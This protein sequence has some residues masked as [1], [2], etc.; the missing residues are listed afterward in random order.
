MPDRPTSRTW[1][2]QPRPLRWLWL[3]VA[4]IQA[5]GIVFFLIVQ[6]WAWVAMAAVGL[7]VALGW[8]ALGRGG[9]TADQE[10]LRAMRPK[11][12][13]VPWNDVLGFRRSGRDLQDVAARLADGTERTLTVP[14]QRPNEL[15][16]L[17]PPRLQEAPVAQGSRLTHAVRMAPT[18]NGPLLNRVDNSSREQRPYSQRQI[19]SLPCRL[20]RGVILPDVD[21]VAPSE[22]GAHDTYY[23]S[24]VGQ[25]GSVDS[26]GAPS[27]KPFESSAYGST[28]T[29]RHCLSTQRLMIRRVRICG[30]SSGLWISWACRP[31]VLSRRCSRRHGR[32]VSSSARASAAR[33]PGWPRWTSPTHLTPSC[34]RVGRQ[35][36]PF[37][38]RRNR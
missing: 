35:P 7:A 38:L 16:E 2:R 37:T 32:M 3:A 8:Y 21:R 11:D 23:G 27:C 15:L 19:R 29:P 25:Y 13:L 26:P 36:G 34:L 20:G 9:T 28:P 10:G 30:S 6:N 24:R 31:A 12:S 18:A 33:S 17:A 1:P 5:V 22:D 14:G 4:S